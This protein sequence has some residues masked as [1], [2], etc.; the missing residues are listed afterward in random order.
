MSISFWLFANSV[1]DKTHDC[2]LFESIL[3]SR[4]IGGYHRGNIMCAQSKNRSYCVLQA[5][6]EF[7]QFTPPLDVWSHI[8]MTITADNIVN[9]FVDGVNHTANKFINYIMT[10]SSYFS[11]LR[12]GANIGDNTHLASF[13]GSLDEFKIWNRVLTDTEISTVA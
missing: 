1:G 12:L 13:D 2:I 8:V 4:A 6:G 7:A 5:F 3:D 11:Q 9:V 10:F